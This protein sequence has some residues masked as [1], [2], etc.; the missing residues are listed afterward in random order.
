MPE[1]PEVVVE[2]AAKLLPSE[3]TIGALPS[4]F[5][6]MFLCQPNETSDVTSLSTHD[7][8]VFKIDPLIHSL[9]NWYSKPAIE[10]LLNLLVNPP[11]AWFEEDPECLLRKVSSIMRERQMVSIATSP[12]IP[13]HLIHWGLSRASTVQYYSCGTLSPTA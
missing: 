8:E 12:T 3:A 2:L 7:F 5:Y 10:A 1:Y 6:S 13:I 9:N 11:S 4:I